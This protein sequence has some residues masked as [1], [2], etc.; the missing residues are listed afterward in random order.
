[1]AIS[2]V[3]GGYQNIAY[4]TTVT[5][6]FTNTPTEGN[7]LVAFGYAR[8]ASATYDWTY[9][10]MSGW[11]FV[12]GVKCSDNKDWIV[13]YYKVAGASESKNAVMTWTGAGSIQLGIEEWSGFTSP[14]LDKYASSTQAYNTSKTSGTTATTTANDELCI[15][16]F[17]LGAAKA[18][19]SF[20][21]SYTNEIQFASNL[22]MMASLIVSSTGAQ[23]TTMSWTT[24]TNCGGVIATFKA[25][26]VTHEC[27]G[28]SAS[29]TVAAGALLLSL[30]LSGA[31]AGVSTGAGAL[32]VTHECAG[33]SASASTAA[34]VLTADDALAGSAAGA[35][36]CEAAINAELAQYGVCIGTSAATGD[37]TVTAPNYVELSTA[38]PDIGA[39]EFPFSYSTAT[40]ALTSGA[41]H[42]CA[43]A[44]AG[45]SAGAGTLALSIA[46]IGDGGQGASAASGELTASLSLIGA[47][48]G[49]ST[50]GADIS[51]TMPLAASSASASASAGDLAVLHAAEGSAASA[52]T[53]SAALGLT[54][55]LSTAIPDVGAYEF[56]FAYSTATG[57]LDVHA[58]V[59]ECVGS[60]AS[61]STATASIVETIGLSGASASSSVA[62]AGALLTASL[63]GSAAGSSTASGDALRFAGL[64]GSAASSSAA[65]ATGMYGTIALPASAH[66]VS[67]ASATLTYAM[68]LMT[69]SAGAN[70]TASS[71]LS[72]SPQ[73]S[74]YRG[75]VKSY[76]HPTQ[77]IN[78]PRPK[79]SR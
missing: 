75:R 55:P 8:T 44:S 22:G 36:T 24:A 71:K 38:I 29:T 21:N 67:S 5:T 48:Q 23:E 70:S 10:G 39:F 41:T 43:G 28:A 3:Q 52:S 20:T 53:A 79:W 42:E 66:A 35:S 68:V 64:A 60:A 14:T 16:G 61:T 13:I 59:Q 78:I 63:S 54:I 62:S 18:T 76:P 74:S 12:T 58:A 19:V 7:L 73:P 31:A 26:T 1:M 46:L 77:R 50:A 17:G 33:T 72:F 32:D 65:S 2:K 34:G 37:V 45:T 30:A 4:T 69:A 11:T 27:V 15:A 49:A 56:P 51:A 47:A 6:A 40:G 25:G 57:A 9:S